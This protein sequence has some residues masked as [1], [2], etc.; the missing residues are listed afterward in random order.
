MEI[1]WDRFDEILQNQPPLEQG[2]NAWV[3]SGKYTGGKPILASDPHLVQ[4]LPSVW[5]QNHLV[6]QQGDKIILNVMGVSMAGCPFVLIG[7]NAHIAWGITLSYADVTDIYLEKLSGDKKT[8]EFQGVQKP[9]QEIDEI[10]QVKG[11]K[12]PFIEKVSFLT[13]Y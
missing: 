6:A 12:E 5:Y 2:S 7:H 4:S 1:N 13:C 9:V 11:Q 8:Y 10:I 3:V